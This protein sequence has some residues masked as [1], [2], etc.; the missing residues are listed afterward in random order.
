MD[1]KGKARRGP[2][3]GRERFQLVIPT[4]A[5][6]DVKKLAGRENRSISNMLATLVSEAINARKEDGRGPMSALVATS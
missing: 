6:E 2:K 3:G 1:E 5:L 4:D